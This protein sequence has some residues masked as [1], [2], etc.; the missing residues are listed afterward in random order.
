MFDD[1]IN[2]DD[3][4]RELDALKAAVSMAEIVLSQAKEHMGIV[5]S[6]EDR[7][8]GPMKYDDVLC[9]FEIGDLST[10][11]NPAGIAATSSLSTSLAD[12]GLLKIL[13]ME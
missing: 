2:E 5:R 9:T 7:E 3:F 11:V 6:F 12:T 8:I 1:G 10:N 4:N 13:P